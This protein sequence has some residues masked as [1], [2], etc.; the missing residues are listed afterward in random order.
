VVAPKYWPS[1][2][3]R[4]L[5]ISL[6][7]AYA[8]SSRY[9]GAPTSL[10]KG[11]VN[12]LT[13]V[14]FPTCNQPAPGQPILGTIPALARV[15]RM[16]S[17][18]T[19]SDSAILRLRAIQCHHIFWWRWLAR[20]TGAVRRS[21]CNA[22]LPSCN[23]IMLGSISCIM[24]STEACPNPQPRSSCQCLRT[25]FG[26]SLISLY[27]DLPNTDSRL[28]QMVAHGFMLLSCDSFQF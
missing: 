23:M 22:R 10:L 9:V 24:P 3:V 20:S 19:F 7:P 4:P 6:A 2:I 17:R 21:N 15:G 27:N 5:R 18:V 25:K 1:A 11:D 28:V 8:T 13:V 16:P 12:S 14:A 26:V